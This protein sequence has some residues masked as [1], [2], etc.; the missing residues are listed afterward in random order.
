VAGL[1]CSLSFRVVSSYFFVG[2]GAGVLSSLKILSDFMSLA[3][4]FEH[5]SK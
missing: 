4:A 1:L 3:I 5:V 2:F